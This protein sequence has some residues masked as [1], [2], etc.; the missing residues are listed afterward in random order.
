MI[1]FM[2]HLRT[3]LYENTLVVM[4]LLTELIDGVCGLMILNLMK[5]EKIVRFMS[6]LKK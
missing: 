3:N 4:S 5:L 1:L 6:V 2:I